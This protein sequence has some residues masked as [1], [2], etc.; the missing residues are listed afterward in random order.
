V[1]KLSEGDTARGVMLLHS[2]DDARRAAEKLTRS[3]SA[4][5][6]WQNLERRVK[7]QDIPPHSWHRRKLIVQDFVPGLDHDYKIVAMADR[8]FVMK[9]PAREGD[10]RASGSRAAREYPT[11]PPAGLLDFTWKVFQSFDAPFAS[12]D[13]MHD[14]S[15]FYLGE[16]QFLRFGTGPIH[17]NPRHFERQA[18]GSWLC[19]EGKCEWEQELARGVATYLATR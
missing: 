12:I 18:D 16:I 8:L 5:D 6:A 4:R 19:V 13:V 9:R 7:G 17:R 3:F 2:A 14:G 10:F 11:E 15:S 1:L